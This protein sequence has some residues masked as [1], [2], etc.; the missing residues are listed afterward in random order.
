MQAAERHPT[1][2]AGPERGEYRPSSTGSMRSGID[3][4]ITQ[5]ADGLRA[6][7]DPTRR[8]ET[9][10]NAGPLGHQQGAMR[11]EM[12]DVTRVDLVPVLILPGRHRDRDD[13]RKIGRLG[14]A[15]AGP[16]RCT[17]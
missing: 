3:E 1:L 5:Y 11:H 16:C 7:P 15:D 13:G 9:G 4:Q 12:T 17:R 8:T 14:R 10:H 2:L 6:W